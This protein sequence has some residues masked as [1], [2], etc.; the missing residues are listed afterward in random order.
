MEGRIESGG[1][2]TMLLHNRALPGVSQTIGGGLERHRD[3]SHRCTRP[4]LRS[5]TP[6]MP[7]TDAAGSIASA[8]ERRR[9]PRQCT[10]YWKKEKDRGQRVRALHPHS[11]PLPRHCRRGR[12]STPGVDASRVVATNQLPPPSR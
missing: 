6:T 2:Q 8:G 3:T 10:E 9:R 5:G 11:R 7:A 1:V 12:R 4:L